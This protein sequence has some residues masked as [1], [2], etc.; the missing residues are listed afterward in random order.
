MNRIEIINSMAASADISRTVAERIFEAFETCLKAHIDA[1]KR[2]VLRGFGSFSRGLPTR[3]A[4]RNP[5]TGVPITYTAYHK[6]KNV[7][8]VS[9]AAFYREVAAAAACGEAQ[10]RRAL[11]GMQA[12]IASNVRKGADVSVYGFGRFFAARRAA[13]MARNPR[14]GEAVRV[15]AHTVPNFRASKAGNAGGKFSAGSGLKALFG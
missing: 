12:T 6:P 8:A 3:K 7:P 10:A 9:S 4:G 2:V 5:R 11:D 1:G 14:T 13:R 15:P